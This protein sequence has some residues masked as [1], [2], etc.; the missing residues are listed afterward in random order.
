MKLDPIAD[1]GGEPGDD[2]DRDDVLG[3]INDRLAEVAIGIQLAVE[4]LELKLR[5]TVVSR[6]NAAIQLRNGSRGIEKS[7]A[8]E[9]DHL[10]VQ[11]NRALRCGDVVSENAVRTA[12]S[13][14][15]HGE[16]AGEAGAGGGGNKI[17]RVEGISGSCG[18]RIPYNPVIYQGLLTLDFCVHSQLGLIGQGEFFTRND[19]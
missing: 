10:V 4:L 13:S 2:L 3:R 8:V 15:R 18:A 12:D 5:H 7:H 19:I 14:E 16:P 17:D 1:G 6:T 11:H 9:H